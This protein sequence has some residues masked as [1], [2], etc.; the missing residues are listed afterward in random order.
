MEI[1][2]GAVATTA[3]LTIKSKGYSA[4]QKL[5]ETVLNIL[6]YIVWLPTLE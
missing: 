5:P 2:L 6:M 4:S 3:L 1:G